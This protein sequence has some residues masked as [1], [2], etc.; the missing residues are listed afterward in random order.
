MIQIERNDYV[1]P[2]EVREE[3]VQGICEAF[4]AGNAWSVF[5]PR[6][7]SLYRRRTFLILKHKGADKYYGFHYE[8][9]G[10]DD[11]LERFNGAEMKEAF[12]VL[13]EA[14]YYIFWIGSIQGYRVSKKPVNEDGIRVTE[15]KD[16]ID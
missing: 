2:T 3:I 16:F 1:Q 7:T 10:S 11:E 4:L 5:H 6:T 13:Q 15:F 9:F 12:K 14:G 8:P